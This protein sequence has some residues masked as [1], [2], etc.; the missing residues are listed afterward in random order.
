MKTHPAV[1]DPPLDPTPTADPPVTDLL[2]AA[3]ARLE[4]SGCVQERV[5]QLL[6]TSRRSV[7]RTLDI[8]L[9]GA[10][11]DAAIVDAAR[12]RLAAT[13]RRGSTRDERTQAEAWLTGAMP[14]ERSH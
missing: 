1:D 4:G 3:R 9:S 5:A 2:L 8:D 7:G 11:Q 12:A 13:A 14:E 10:R 6:G